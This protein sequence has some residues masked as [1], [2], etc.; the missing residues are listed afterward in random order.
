MRI[1]STRPHRTFWSVPASS[2]TPPFDLWGLR[3]PEVCG[4]EDVGRAED[5]AA[6]TRVH[7]APSHRPRW[8]S[9][10]PQRRQRCAARCEG[11][12]GDK[13]VWRQV[14]GQEQ[15]EHVADPGGAAA[16]DHRAPP[17][18]SDPRGSHSMRALR[19]KKHSTSSSSS[20]PARPPACLTHAAPSAAH[21]AAARHAVGVR[22]A[23][24]AACARRKPLGDGGEWGAPMRVLVDARGRPARPAQPRPAS[25]G[26]GGSAATAQ[27]ACG[28]C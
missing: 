21:S 20:N 27:Q 9:R 26:A 24:G 1:V 18:S 19:L 15:H 28:S 16:A 3:V 10:R 14:C 17:A 25:P 23:D 7:G 22:T 8:A 12:R 11:R 4:V 6:A 5:Y 13:G 2:R